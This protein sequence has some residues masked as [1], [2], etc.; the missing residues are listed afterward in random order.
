MRAIVSTFSSLLW[1]DIDLHAREVRTDLI[2]DRR[3]RYFGLTRMGD[4]ILV[5]ARRDAESGPGAIYSF[6]SKGITAE[7]VL[8]HKHLSD[9]HQIRVLGPWLFIIVGE[10]SLVAVFDTRTW[11]LVQCIELEPFVPAHLRHEAPSNRPTDVYHFNSLTFNRNRLFVL[12][13]NHGRASFALEIMLDLKENRPEAIGLAAVHEGLGACSHDFVYDDGTLHV[14][15]SSSGSVILRGESVDTR[16][17]LAK[18]A[19]VAFLRGMAVSRDHLVVSHGTWAAERESRVYGNS[20]ISVI[21][22]RSRVTV[23]QT[24]FGNF[25]NTSDI[26]LLKPPDLSDSFWHL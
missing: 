21:D 15:D 22:R 25:G 17:E 13:H 5:A 10:G 4:R 12:A 3:G 7:C 18:E 23:F 24:V 11:K 19:C 20:A 2:E 16:I 9:L 26:L 14:L 1:L 6:D 8:E